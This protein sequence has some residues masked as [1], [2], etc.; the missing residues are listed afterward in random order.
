MKKI[1]IRFFLFFFCVF[2][3]LIVTGCSNSSSSDKGKIAENTGSSN[4]NGSTNNSSKYTII[5][6]DGDGKTIET[7]KNVLYG[8]TPEYNGKTPT[9]KATKQYTYTFKGWSPEITSVT[10]NTT[11]VAQ[12]T[13]ELVKYNITWKNE[14]G[15]LLGTSS[16]EYG[17]VP[18]YTGETPTKPSNDTYEY[19][20]S[21]WYPALSEVTK[22]MTYSA[23]YSKAYRYY[24]ISFV[25]YDGTELYKT[26][27]QAGKSISNSTLNSIKPTKENDSDYYYTF[28]GWSPSVTAAYKDQVYEAKFTQIKHPYT[29]KFNL[30]GG[31]SDSGISDLK[32]NRLSSKDF[33]FDLH[34]GSQSFRGWMYNGQIVFDAKG[35]QKT[36]IKD[37]Y[38]G[39]TFDALYEGESRVTIAYLIDTIL[40]NYTRY[41]LP[42]DIGIT[43][44]S[45]SYKNHTNIDLTATV[46]EGY[47]FDGWYN[48]STKLSKDENYTYGLSE[49]DVTITARFSKQSYGLRILT[50]NS[51]AGSVQ[52]KDG[53]VANDVYKTITYKDQ[54]T[55]YAVL[56]GDERFLGWYD[57]ND[58]FVSSLSTYT[59]S[60]PNKNLTLV[61]K[62]NK[63]TINYILNGG[64]NNPDNP[65]F[66]RIEDEIIQLQ[67]PTRDGYNFLGWETNG[68]L[69][70]EIDPKDAK[71]LIVVAKWEAQ[72]YS[73]TIDNQ[74]SGVTISG[75]TSGEKYECNTYVT[76]TATGMPSRY[77]IKWSRDDEITDSFVGDSYRFIVPSRDITISVSTQLPYTVKDNKVYMGTYPQSLVTDAD[78]VESLNLLAGNLP[79]ANN[80][81]KWTDYK[82]YING[83]ITSY[84]YYKDIDIDKNGTKDYR[85]VYF[86]SYRPYNYMDTATNPES[87]QEENGYELNTIYWF[88]YETIE[89][90]IINDYTYFDR[91]LVVANLNLDAQEY[92]PSNNE[93]KFSHNSGYGYANNYAYS[94]IRKWLN[95][96]FYNTA[97]STIEKSAIKSTTVDNS[98]ATTATNPNPCAGFNTTDNIFLLSYSEAENYNSSSIK[99]GVSD[100]AKCQGIKTFK[101]GSEDSTYSW[102]RSP[103]E[104]LTF[105]AVYEF[106]YGGLNYN[107]VDCSS[108]GVRPALWIG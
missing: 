53:T 2:G 83:S 26:K 60:M 97:F 22:D 43:T 3:A 95:D 96:T 64:E 45:N 85:G 99:G 88:K 80:L 35:N 24:N 34:K 28:S 66:Y 39:M 102:L 61:A 67:N 54:V 71:D 100:Y 52:I 78:I 18:S 103:D 25:N 1:I 33:K 11:Y 38:N 56:N 50:N 105:V 73:I 79:S 16:V 47:K 55:I 12:F 63:F 8:T 44:Q 98:A 92:Y 108:M 81:N 9:K 57:S 87:V 101:N 91:I 58:N 6:K 46:Y 74:L 27:I 89:W 68:S 69:I 48:G 65:S 13:Q 84:M 10:K 32:T 75:I 23:R 31:E 62:W 94:N 41:T 7:D 15:T 76:L 70:T 14:D 17:R 4:N 42:D 77:T 107:S 29:F 19:S 20:F 51:S 72:K 59:F 40:T 37:L 36:T 90:D 49:E 93:T 21:N 86:T 30:N 104:M 5:W 82:Y 106:G